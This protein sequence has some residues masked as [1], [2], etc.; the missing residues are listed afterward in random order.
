MA[1][2]RGFQLIYPNEPVGKSLKAYLKE[3][4]QTAREHIAVGKAFKTQNNWAQFYAW[5]IENL[6]NF[7]HPT[8]CYPGPVQ[9]KIWFCVRNLPS[10]TFLVN[11]ALRPHWNDKLKLL[12]FR[13]KKRLLRGAIKL[14]RK[15]YRY[16]PRFRRTRRY[17]KKR[18]PRRRYYKRRYYRRR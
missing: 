14:R 15:Y 12:R 4:Y 2:P 6:T 8:R 3:G 1:Q 11:E 7:P 5:C 10:K 9:K 13:Q 18:Y 17:Y 16:K